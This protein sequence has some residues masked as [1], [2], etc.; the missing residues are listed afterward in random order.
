M[1][2]A[3]LHYIWQTQRFLTTN[4][5]TTDGEEIRV[6][7]KGFLNTN[8][9][10]DFT[11]ARL[12]IGDVEWAGNV[13]VHVNA[14]EWYAHKHQQ[15]EA[16]ENVI[17]HVVWQNDR[18][19]FRADGS[20][21]PVLELV[22][23]VSEKLVEKQSQLINSQSLIPCENQFAEVSEFTKVSML[24]SALTQR[25]QQKAVV[26]AELFT[27]NNSDWE[28]TA[29]QALAKNF[30][31]KLNAE[32]MLQ[33][34]QNLP[35]KILQK[36]RNN[37]VQIEAL[38]FGMAGFLEESGGD[39]AVKLKSEYD[40]L[41]L[42]YGLKSKQL[43]A[44][45][46]KFLRTRP[47]NFPTIRLAQFAALVAS[48]QSF[49]SLFTQTVDVDAIKK[50]FEIEQSDYWQ[51]NYHFDK[52]LAKPLKQLGKASIENLLVNSVVPTLV[53]YAQYVD[54]REFIERAEQI[55]ESLPPENNKITRK[56]ESL[57]LKIQSSFDS[58][59]GIEL[60]NNYCQKRKCMNCKIGAEVLKST[61]G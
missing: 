61:S 22:N 48:Q 52:P 24:G 54:N 29:Y 43:N 23:I 44:H 5:K 58:Q 16:Y 13:E 14:A 3:F 53:C 33:L 26:V 47:A 30:G 37:S 10:P 59:A 4:L 49:F 40:F 7:K 20:K 31:F 35:L 8:A 56:W 36:H 17:L 6:F 28:E 32:P 27:A 34:A 60:F 2:E 19:V 21:I 15:D 46:W 9:G 50:A 39:F 41:S 1:Q 45:E 38:L 42:K 25:L 55:L 51:N 18:D 11:N 12:Q 57:G